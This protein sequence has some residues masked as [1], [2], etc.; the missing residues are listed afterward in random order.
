MS[1]HATDTMATQLTRSLC[2]LRKPCRGV[3]PGLG[4]LSESLCF[5]GDFRVWADSHCKSFAQAH[6][7]QFSAT[8]IE[9]RREYHTKMR[10]PCMKDPQPTIKH[11]GQKIEG[12]SWT[13]ERKC[14]GS[15]EHLKVGWDVRQMGLL[16]FDYCRDAVDVVPFAG[17]TSGAARKMP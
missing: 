11:P 8:Q 6:Y 14:S 13:S 12:G 7:T 4:G 16:R 1:G 3:L 15:A 9:F 17:R 2:L 5:L 10:G